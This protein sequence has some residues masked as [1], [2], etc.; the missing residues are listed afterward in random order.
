MPEYPIASPARLRRR[1]GLPLLIL[2]GTGVTV[3]AGIYILIG[4]VVGHAQVYS[5]WAF[6]LAAAVM[7]FTAASYAEL[8]VRYPVSA[9]EAAYVRVAFDSRILS[10]AVGSI[11]MATGIMH[12]DDR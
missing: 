10:T 1:I 8:A 4:A 12:S 3:G 5:S 9:G 6:A 7:A 11:R 2:Y